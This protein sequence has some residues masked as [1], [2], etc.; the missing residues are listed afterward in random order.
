MYFVE[1]RIYQ[2]GPKIS[3]HIVSNS[4][5]ETKRKP[6]VLDMKCIGGGGDA[7]LA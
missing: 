4:E 7:E 3:V 5:K 6:V 2:L 1:Y